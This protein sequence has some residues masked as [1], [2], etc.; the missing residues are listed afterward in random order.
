MT[1][2]QKEA[3]RREV[4]EEALKIV[5]AFPDVGQIEGRVTSAGSRQLELATTLI[6]D[7]LAASQPAPAARVIRAKD[8]DRL[9]TAI[10]KAHGRTKQPG[11]IRSEFVNRHYTVE[12]DHQRNEV[13]ATPKVAPAADTG[14]AVGFDWME[15]IRGLERRSFILT[16]AGNGVRAVKDEIGRWVE[17]DELV[18]AMGS[19]QERADLAHPAPLDVERVRGAAQAVL[20]NADRP[21]SR[22]LLGNGV[23][24]DVWI[25]YQEVDQSCLDAL[26][27]ALRQKESEA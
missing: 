12:V 20:D 4:L 27:A 14:Q 11:E 7:A 9:K 16:P 13:V 6:R 1:P 19:A 22:K 21:G 15:V 18:R 3:F 26:R 10:Y 8:M 17:R 25:D 23:E 5:A 24:E 2:E